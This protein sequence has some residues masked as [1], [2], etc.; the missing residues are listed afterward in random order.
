MC[1]ESAIKRDN[2]S[3]LLSNVYFLCE[4][5]GEVIVGETHS[6]GSIYVVK[7]D[8][9]KQRAVKGNIFN[10]PSSFSTRNL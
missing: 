3:Y 7:Q 8:D 9:K 10:R 2:F 5:E 1:L 6:G 4:V